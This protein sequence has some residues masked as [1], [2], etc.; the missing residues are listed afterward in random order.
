MPDH[1]DCLLAGLRVLDLA[2]EPGAMTGR[3]LADL[4]ASVVRVETG[5]GDPLRRA[6]PLGA[7]G[8]SVRFVAWSAGKQI[9]PL[10]GPGDPVLGELLRSADVVLT[11][12]GWPG[13]LEPDRS[14]ADDHV[15]WVAVTPFGLGGARASW[16]ASDL[17]IMAASGNMYATGDPDRAPIRP[18]EPAAYA[19]GGAEAAFAVLSALASGR[20][21]DVDLSIQEAVMVA[22]MGAAGRSG[23]TG[24]RGRRVGANVGSTR[25]IWPCRDGFVSF[26]LRGGKARQANLQAITRLVAEEG[27]PATTL[28]AQDWA[29]YEHTRTPPEVLEAI[30]TEIGAYFLR[31]TMSQLYETACS[32]GLML[33]PVNSPKELLGS[34]QLAARE[35]FGPV[36]EVARFPRRF[37]KTTSLDGSLEEPGA[38]EQVRLLGSVSE[39][40]WGPPDGERWVGARVQL[41]RQ[42]TVEDV[43][44]D[45]AQGAWSGTRIVE[46][47]SGAAGPIATRYFAEHGATV[48][49]V[50]SR[51]RPD[52]LRLYGLRASSP[53]GLDG[54]DLFDALNPGKLSVTINLKHE[55]GVEVFLALVRWADA[56]E[57]NFA[58]RALRG[59]G[60]DYRRL[61]AEKPDLVMV[62]S[63]LMGQ[64]GPHRDYPGFGGQGSALAGY[65]FLTGWP[66]REPVGPFGTIT[67]SLAPRFAAVALAA[68]LLYRRRTGRGVHLDI[69]QAETAVYSLSPWMLD[70][71]TNG[72]IRGRSGNR[73]DRFVPH[74]VFPCL[75]E[76]RWMGIACWDDM[77]WAALAEVLG[78]V[79]AGLEKFDDRRERVEE[80]EALVADFTRTRR[81]EEVAELLQSRG[82]EAV[83]VADF[84]DAAAD[85]ALLDRRHYVDLAHGCLGERAYE[86][87]G[88]RLSRS[89]SGYDRPSPLLG[90]HTDIVLGELLGIGAQERQRLREVGALE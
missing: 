68:G 36:G 35:F 20:S 13:A 5:A 67:D 70:Y 37:V 8:I 11:T 38:R 69:S 48:V 55:Q 47:G 10:E 61:A 22:S 53:C 65:N 81:R 17:G 18:A 34:A 66:D 59:L 62:S 85:P 19:H 51:S 54:S 14:A 32:T 76:D 77:M 44:P 39:L 83:P 82:V 15:V 71:E 52:F 57:E 60:L 84:V 90:E 23:R 27:L 58:P 63:C 74:G 41:P 9:L 4:G 21:Q 88:F 29:T 33:A 50:E 40:G 49:R 80:V 79:P 31:H 45:T 46:L 7:D 12:P 64:T 25:E 30:S 28:E 89:A 6:P 75:G 72:R 78:D 56:I 42:R 26:G 3:M 87:N 16:R 24:E 86:R 43:V 73:S 2:A 1:T